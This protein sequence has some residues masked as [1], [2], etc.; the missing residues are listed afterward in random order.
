MHHIL[1]Q[2]MNYFSNFPHLLMSP[3]KNIQRWIKKQ[4]SKNNSSTSH[5]SYSI[6]RPK[7]HFLWCYLWDPNQGTHFR[8]VLQTQRIPTAVSIAFPCCLQDLRQSPLKPIVSFPLILKARRPIFQFSFIL[9]LPSCALPIPFWK[10]H[11]FTDHWPSES[12]FPITAT[13]WLL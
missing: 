1:A 11:Q 10:Y 4:S 2:I 9:Y 6:L 7:P 12:S 5:F 8:A 3:F 13:P